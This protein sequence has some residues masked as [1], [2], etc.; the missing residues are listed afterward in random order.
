MR[1]LE[2]YAPYVPIFGCYSQIVKSLKNILFEPKYPSK[3]AS[4]K[5]SRPKDH[6]SNSTWTNSTQNGFLQL[7]DASNTFFLFRY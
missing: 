1:N 4:R 2:K 6:C 5:N 7:L 3:I